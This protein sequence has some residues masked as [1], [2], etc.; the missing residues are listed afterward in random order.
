MNSENPVI[1]ATGPADLISYAQHTLGFAPSNSLVAIAT[2]RPN[3]GAVLR[4]DLPPSG[5]SVSELAAYAD[6]FSGYLASDHRASGCILLLIRD[7]GTSVDCPVMDE[8]RTLA[9]ILK[10]TFFTRELPVSELWLVEGGVLWSMD[11]S[12]H[13]GTLVGNGEGSNV[14][15]T[16]AIRNGT[17]GA[18]D[19]ETLP[20]PAPAAAAT[21]QLAQAFKDFRFDTSNGHDA[22]VLQFFW[23]QSWEF[24]LSGWSLPAEPAERAFLIAGLSV[25][26]LRDILVGSAALG[27]GRAVSGAAWL[28]LIQDRVAERYRVEPTKVNADTYSALFHAG[29]GSAPEWRRMDRLRSACTDLIAESHG[30]TAS[31]VRVIAAW[32]EWARGR[33]SVASDIVASLLADDPSHSLGRIV[34]RLSDQGILSEWSRDISTA[35]IRQR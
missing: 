11:G 17:A 33:S 29:T 1:R 27:L 30:N 5:E 24:V 7:G 13:D 4:A 3:L 28:G 18:V 16:L 19:P 32:I 22:S 26:S 2:S 9:R 8:D 15:T 20:P 21:P 6:Q 23:L 12:P 25:D 35:W 34:E 31:A 14:F 10:C